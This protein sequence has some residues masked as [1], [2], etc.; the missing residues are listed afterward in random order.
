MSLLLTPLE[1]RVLGCLIEKEITTPEYYPM[2]INA[3]KLACNQKSNRDPVMNLD[4][5][6][7]LDAIESLSRK[8]VAWRKPVADS[9]VPKYAHRLTALYTFSPA[10]LA[11]LAE[12]FIRGPQT[13]GELRTHGNRMHP[14]ADLAEVEATLEHLMDENFGPFVLRLPTLP[15]KREHRYGHLFAGREAVENVAAPEPEMETASVARS[16]SGVQQELEQLRTQLAEL[17]ERVTILE[18]RGE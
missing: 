14:F 17:E 7:V 15:G 13:M 10:E 11:V 8:H 2:T 5:N 18:S 16:S 12:L 4:D 1:V 9:R 3:I 6:V